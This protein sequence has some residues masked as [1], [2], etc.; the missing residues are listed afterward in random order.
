VRVSQITTVVLGIVANRGFGI[1]F[2]KQNV[3][4]M[5]SR[6]PSP[7][8]ASGNFG[9]DPWVLLWKGRTTEGAAVVGGM[10]V[11]ASFTALTG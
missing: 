5:G 4:Y 8:A 11:W 6:W 3:A 7:M 1:D 9:L 10:P 2:E